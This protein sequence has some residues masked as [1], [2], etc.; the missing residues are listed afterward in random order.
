M[1]RLVLFLILVLLSSAS[2]MAKEYAIPVIEVEV[3]IH[4]DGKVTITEHRT[5]TFDGSYS[6]ANYRLPKQGYDRVYDIRVSENGDPFYNEND[7][8]TGSFSV[9]ESSD[10]WDIRWNFSAEDEQRT[11]T[12]TYTLDGALTTGTE[13]SQFFWNYAAAGRERSQERISI[14]IALAGDVAPDQLH[15]WVRS[16]YGQIESRTSNGAFTFEGTDI[17]RNRSVRLRTVF[18]TSVFDRSR[19]SINDPG[20]SL[21][22]A[23]EN[24]RSY[25]ERIEQEQAENA[26]DMALAKR[27]AAVI[28]VLSIGFFVWF[29]RTYGSRFKVNDRNTKSLMAPGREKPAIASWLLFNRVVS[30]GQM[31]ATVLDLA[32]RGF[33]VVKEEEPDEEKK[34]W[35]DPKPEFHLEVKTTPDERD[36][37]EFERTL[38]DF[39]RGRVPEK[40]T[41]M[42]EIFKAGEKE[43]T[44]FWEQFKKD[45][46][47]YGEDQEWFD[48][49]SKQG[50]WKNF[51]AQIIL[52]VA[53]ATMIFV[54]HPVAGLSMITCFIMSVLSL[55]I[56]RRTQKGEEAY[57]DWKNY[58][59]ALKEAKGH[60][61]PVDRLSM[62]FI[63]AVAFGLNQ[64][65]LESLFEGQE[66]SAFA[67]MY[68]LVLMP[69]STNTPG[70]FVSS[71]STL[72]AT[73]TTVSGGGGGVGA[74]AGAA[75]GGASGGAG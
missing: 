6:W 27:I 48:P 63:Y 35:N 56:I 20:F 74:S 15:S 49:V 3:Q 28:S 62:H 11:F 16:P 59:D 44:K 58:R 5:Y 1:K 17:S 12:L 72:A 69:G 33:F 57:R 22:W 64:N 36:L 34:W 51:G 37:V 21:E 32:R 65:H 4:S 70:D 53:A 2:L 67:A 47:K 43:V 42:K 30:S 50:A 14:S 73:G 66:E 26:A 7:E 13:W 46:K 40:G 54:I 29:Y 18:P 75:G 71:I 45:L 38:L 41:A 8:T 23:A 24:E 61:I 52:C 68:W 9:S 19:I 31:M 55:V 60:S 39:V 10:A 25:R